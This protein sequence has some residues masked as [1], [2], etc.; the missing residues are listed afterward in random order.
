MSSKIN[1][2]QQVLN[3]IMS[4]SESDQPFNDNKELLKQLT[5]YELLNVYNTLYHTNYGEEHLQY[6]YENN[7]TSIW[8]NNCIDMIVKELQTRYI[9]NH[10]P[11]TVQHNAPLIKEDAPTNIQDVKL[12]QLSENDK[13]KLRIQQLEYENQMLK[14]Y[15]QNKMSKQIVKYIPIKYKEFN[16]SKHN[17]ANNSKL[18]VEGI[19]TRIYKHPAIDE[20]KKAQLNKP[21]APKEIIKSTAYGESKQFKLEHCNMTFNEWSKLVGNSSNDKQMDLVH[22]TIE[23]IR[24]DPFNWKIYINLMLMVENS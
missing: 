18:I 1:E 12:K 11:T 2:N 14:D 9:N 21:I 13:L 23:N 16:E 15:I 4:V 5:D 17:K 6:V 20:I 24:K 10:P 8:R 19:P 22:K 7:I 3:Q